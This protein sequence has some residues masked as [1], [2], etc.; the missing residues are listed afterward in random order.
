MSE[1]LKK[2]ESQ[3]SD[4]HLKII[5]YDDPD[6]VEEDFSKF[7]NIEARKNEYTIVDVQ[8]TSLYFHSR[9]WHIVY[10][11]YTTKR[12]FNKKATQ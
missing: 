8:H 5:Y 2:Y 4:L 11:K 10:I 9:V 6:L 7:V 12:F 3:Y 1:I